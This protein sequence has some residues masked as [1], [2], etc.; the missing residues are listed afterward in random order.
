VLPLLLSLLSPPAHAGSFVLGTTSEFDLGQG[1]NWARIFPSSEGWQIT[2]A[3]DGDYHVA[4][5]TGTDGT[6]TL[7]HDSIVAITDDGGLVDHAIERCPDG[8]FLHVASANLD[9]PNDSAYADRL[10]QDFGIQASATVEER[11]PSNAHNDMAVVCSDL[12]QG[13]T[14]Q[15]FGSQQVLFYP[16]GDDARPGTPQPI[17][18]ELVMTGGALLPDPDNDRVIISAG[19]AGATQGI[20][21]GELSSSLRLSGMHQLDVTTGSL[22]PYWPQD[23]LAVGDYFL[24]AFMVRDD[25][26]GSDTGNVHLAVLDQDLQLVESTAIS[27]IDLATTEGGHRPGLA[28]SGD[29]LLV[30][31]DRQNTVRLFEVQLDIEAMGIDPG[32]EDS[33]WPG[34]SDAGFAEDSGSGG[35]SGDAGDAGDGGSGDGGGCGC[36]SGG[37]A[38]AGLLA[39]LLGVVGVA[40]RRSGR[41]PRGREGLP[42]TTG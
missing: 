21:V 10:G 20:Q 19:T 29:T 23:L 41:G 3:F 36:A 33:G 26:Q 40:R 35:G 17:A 28:R 12:L 16:L 39:G 15:D 5:L 6:W 11:V 25:S 31:W 2:F 4:D 9:S 38:S 18:G 13:V 22:R 32:T 27:H 7:S 14:F 34:G 24:L 8:G 30:S 1:G 42:G 37:R